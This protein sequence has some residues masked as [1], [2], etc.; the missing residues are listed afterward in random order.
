M[1]EIRISRS[2]SKFVEGHGFV[3]H[4]DEAA[5]M[6]FFHCLRRWSANKPS[7][8]KEEIVLEPMTTAGCELTI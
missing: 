2:P 1:S 3:G 5:L 4:A 8:E 6:D 7:G